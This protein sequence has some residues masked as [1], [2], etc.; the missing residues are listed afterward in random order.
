MPIT[1]VETT[2]V[3]DVSAVSDAV[4]AALKTVGTGMQ[5]VIVSTLPYALGVVG[6]V[7]VVSLGVTVFKKLSAKA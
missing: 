1:L 3:V 4:V 2:Q 7:M 6:S 5:N